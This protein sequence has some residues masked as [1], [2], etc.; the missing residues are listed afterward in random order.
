MRREVVWLV[1]TFLRK[2]ALMA[3]ASASVYILRQQALMLRA[4]ASV[5]IFVDAETN[6]MWT[7]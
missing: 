5:Y 2:Q 3:C 7:G 1:Y 4:S 6:D